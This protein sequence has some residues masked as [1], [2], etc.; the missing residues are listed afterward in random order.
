M[1]SIKDAKAQEISDR[2]ADDAVENDRLPEEEESLAIETDD[3]EALPSVEDY[4]SLREAEMQAALAEIRR[5]SDANGGYVTYDEINR[6]LPQQ[7]VDAVETEQYLKILEQLGVHVI[8]EEEVS[9]WLAEKAGERRQ[10]PECTGDSIRM[11]M[12]QMGQTELLSP[13]EEW[14]IFKRIENAECEC[15]RIF[16]R[17][18]FAPKMYAGVLDR[19]EGQNIRFDH[20]VS[21]KYEFDRETYVGSI[22]ALRRELNRAKSPRQNETCLKRLFYSQRILEELYAQADE[23]MFLPY[24]RLVRDL[25]ELQSVRASKKRDD[26]I[27]KVRGEMAEFEE[28]FGVPREE[29]VEDFSRLRAALREGQDARTRVIEANLRLVVS[30]VKR[31]MNRGLSLLDLI[32]EGNTGLMKSVEKFEYRRGYKFS[33]Y[34]TWWIRQAATRAIADQSRTI[35]IPVHMVETIHK[36][37][38]EEKRLLHRLGREPTESEL[39]Q[40]CGMSAQEVLSVKRMAQRP[41]SLQSKVGDDDACYG[42]FVPDTTSVDPFQATEGHFLREQLKAVLETLG[43]REREVI[44][45]RFGLSDGFSRTLEEVGQFFNVTRERVRQIEAKALRKLR[46]PRRICMLREYSAK[47][48]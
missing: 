17:F 39:G 36:V 18:A 13:E 38:R 44:D 48:A 29:F 40:A 6:I 26:R 25:V 9:S 5:R 31:Y 42:D 41:V 8:K 16:N 20:V 12:R 34:A 27:A 46:H 28:Q 14:Q 4:S 21:D 22:P 10:E 35:R 32:Q 11:Y 23:T 24:R 45:Y 1:N 15:R 30:I 19:L 47:L 2:V 3:V 43:E 37:V 7:L 33:T